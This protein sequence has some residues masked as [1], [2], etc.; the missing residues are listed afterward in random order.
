M[1]RSE[2]ENPGTGREVGTH[3]QAMGVEEDV[4][5]KDDIAMVMPEED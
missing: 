5:R 4:E 3:W 2:K 1:L